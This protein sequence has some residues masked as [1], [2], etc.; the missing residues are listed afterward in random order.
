MLVLMLP[1]L[2]LPLLLIIRTLLVLMLRVLLLLLPLLLLLLLLLPLPL[3]LPMLLSLF[4]PV[5]NSSQLSVHFRLP[6][7]SLRDLMSV[8]RPS[9]LVPAELLLD[10]VT[11]H[12]D[13]GKWSGDPLMVRVDQ[14]RYF[15]A[16]V[17]FAVVGGVGDGDVGVA[18]VVGTD[19]VVGVGAVI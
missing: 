12:A 15:L 6:L 11:Y 1:L 14:C 3:P 9:G 5:P 17:V 19:A 8:V 13:P 7:V 2:L 18:I 4:S 16:V 10:A